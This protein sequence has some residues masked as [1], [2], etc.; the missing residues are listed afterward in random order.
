MSTAM[1]QALH[2]ANASFRALGRRVQS[3]PRICYVQAAA[4]GPVANLDIKLAQ[5]ARLG[6][7]HLLIS[8]PFSAARASQ[9]QDFKR[10]HEALQVL[11]DAYHGLRDI[12][13]RC[14]AAGLALWT[15]VMPDYVAANGTVAN[16]RPDLFRAPDP[17]RALDPRSYLP[18]GNVA[19]A[20]FGEA[21]EALVEF[22]V[23]QIR[24]W[25]EAG[26]SGIRF[27][28]LRRLPPPLLRQIVDTLRA[29][30]ADV[31]LAG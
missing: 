30:N 2:P 24:V 28:S 31:T 17:A 9:I 3:H 29:D 7:S 4:I 25:R 26:V 13:R 8:S 18:E 16:E 22:W 11:G 27:A 1:Q 10:L 23:Q 19:A 20:R 21:G 12:A 6:F 15:D 14:A 5:I